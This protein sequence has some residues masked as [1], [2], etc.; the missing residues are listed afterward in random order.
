MLI[1]F[2]PEVSLIPLSVKSE[3][4][5]HGPFCFNNYKAAISGSSPLSGDPPKAGGWEFLSSKN[6]IQHRPPLAKIAMLR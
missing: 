5:Q 3:M 6:S 1:Q 2:E 4:P